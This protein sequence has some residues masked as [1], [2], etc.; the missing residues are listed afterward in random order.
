MHSL[1]FGG[2]IGRHA[3]L[4]ILWAAMSVR[5]RFPSEAQGRSRT[6]SLM[7]S[8]PAFIFVPDI[9]F[10][11]NIPSKQQAQPDSC[12]GRGRCGYCC[13]G[14]GCLVMDVVDM[15]VV[16]MVV[17]SWL[18]RLNHTIS[19]YHHI[20]PPCHT[21]LR[22]HTFY[23]CIHCHAHCCTHCRILSGLG[24]PTLHTP[25]VFM[26]RPPSPQFSGIFPV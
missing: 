11:V 7:V 22:P 3:G 26:P 12:C 6:E 10:K 23:C 1:C 8:R 15:A 20:I 18:L 2:G 14:H 4:K 21:E 17:W 9:P 13:C 24:H 16:D 5:V 19:S 25:T